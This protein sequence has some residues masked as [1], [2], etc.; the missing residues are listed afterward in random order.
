MNDSVF[1]GKVDNCIKSI[2]ENATLTEMELVLNSFQTGPLMYYPKEFLPYLGNLHAK[3]EEL[4]VHIPSYMDATMD[5]KPDTKVT[6]PLYADTVSGEA[7]VGSLEMVALRGYNPPGYAWISNGVRIE[8]L[9]EVNI[10]SALSNAGYGKRIIPKRGQP[11]TPNL[12]GKLYPDLTAASI[13]NMMEEN[14]KK[15]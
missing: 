12:Y 1:V 13:T 5:V 6:L 3:L 15:A 11:I 8:A 9:D 10:S 2:K 14:K 7:K 4:Q